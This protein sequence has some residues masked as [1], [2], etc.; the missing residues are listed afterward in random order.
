MVTNVELDKEVDE[1][2]NIM[3]EK[4]RLLDEA[5]QVMNEKLK[6]M[7]E[8]TLAKGDE[9]TCTIKGK[10]KVDLED[11]ILEPNPPLDEQEPIHQ[12]PQRIWR[13]NS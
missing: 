9:G 5:I 2:K 6:E 8:A 13:E 10:K 7:E 12:G 11:E 4:T 3:D 1:Q